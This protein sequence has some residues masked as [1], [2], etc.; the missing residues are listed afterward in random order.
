MPETVALERGS[1][2]AL[3]LGDIAAAALARSAGRVVATDAGP[4]GWAHA[5]GEL[6]WLGADAVAHPRAIR[7]AEVP[8][9][10]IAR[11]DAAGAQRRPARACPV[12][13]APALA[14]LRRLAP[15]L[16]AQ[17]PARGFAP[18]LGCGVLAFPLSAR[19]DDARGAL[20][21]ARANRP[22][23]FLRHALRLL[24]VGPGLTPSGDDLIGGAL[25]LVRAAHP[26]SAA[27][28]AVAATLLAAAR[29]RTHPVSAALLADL[30]GGASFAALHDLLDATASGGAAET[31]LQRALA[32]SRI[33][34]V[35]GWD[36]LTGL[37]LSAP[38][39]PTPTP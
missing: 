14:A 32:V 10:R 4:R 31:L 13:G 19:G 1:V 29:E 5:A 15:H 38:A 35:S 9:G 25:F 18:L 37:L 6:V 24:G 16:A 36:L 23:R 21:E 3:A 12:I 11:I 26:E 20:A 27:W 22:E 8:T 28:R 34:N 2:R 17:A 30:A 7:L 33:G 39:P